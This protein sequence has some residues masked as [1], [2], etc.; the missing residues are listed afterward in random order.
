MRNSVPRMLQVVWE[1]KESVQK[2]TSHLKTAKEYFD[3]IKKQT[4][5]YRLPVARPTRPEPGDVNSKPVRK[6]G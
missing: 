1:M 4:A 5:H 3:Y 2:E 6:A